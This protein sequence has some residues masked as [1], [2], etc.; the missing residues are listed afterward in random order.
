MVGHPPPGQDLDR[1]YHP[2]DQMYPNPSGQ[3][4]EG[5]YPPLDRMYPSKKYQKVLHREC[6]RHTACHVAST[7]FASLPPHGRGVPHPVLARG[8]QSCPRYKRGTP[9]CPGSWGAGTSTQSWSGNVL[10]GQGI[11]ICS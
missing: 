2:L 3:D 4:L 9:S 10:P 7:C 6:K 11:P 1:T 5:T 8:I